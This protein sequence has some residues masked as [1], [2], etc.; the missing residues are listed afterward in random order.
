MAFAVALDFRQSA[1]VNQ[2]GLLLYGVGTIRPYEQSKKKRTESEPL[3]M[4]EALIIE[5]ED[6]PTDSDTCVITV[7]RPVSPGTPLYFSTPAEAAS[8]P[9]AQRLLEPGKL[10]AV[11]LQENTITLLK[12]LD[13]VPWADVTPGVEVIVREHFEQQDKVFDGSDRDMT[14]DEEALAQR[15]QQVLDTE[16]NPMVASH[17]GVIQVLGVKGSAL[18]VHM[19]GGCQGCAMSTATLKQGVEQVVQRNFA[20]I[21][22]IL[23]TTDHAAGTNPYYRP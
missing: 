1:A 23:D 16:I 15:V 20:E 13:G 21:D 5:I 11:L 19:G 4:A 17:G 2:A 6:A 22:T 14:S 7:N 8:S 18:Y 10:E 12:P 9:M 3:P